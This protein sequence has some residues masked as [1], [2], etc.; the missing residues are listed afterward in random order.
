MTEPELPPPLRAWQL[1]GQWLREEKFWRDI[2][3]R[4][5]AGVLTAAIVYLGALV[6]GYLHTPELGAGLAL[7]LGLAGSAVLLLV[8]IVLVSRMP[9]RRRS[10]RPVALRLVVAVLLVL[11]AV[12]L[13]A[14]VIAD[15][16]RP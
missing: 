9:A 4:V 12:S 5:L 13:A 6:L 2:G 14:A 8:A 10:G 11:G 16:L 1:P 7:L 15:A 3:T